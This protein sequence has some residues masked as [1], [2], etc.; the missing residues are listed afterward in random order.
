MSQNLLEIERTIQNLSLEEQLWLLE[1]IA[2]QVRKRVQTGNK[3]FD[4]KY[5]EEQLRAMANNPSIQSEIAAINEEFAI[6]EMDSL[7][8]L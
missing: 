2:R 7:D 1:R 3:F 8:K 5:M 6:T 4:P